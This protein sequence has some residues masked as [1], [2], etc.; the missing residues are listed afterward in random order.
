VMIIL[1]T[2]HTLR[3]FKK[4]DWN[5]FGGLGVVDPTNDLP[6]IN[7]LFH[8][9]ETALIESFAQEMK[10]NIYTFNKSLIPEINNPKNPSTQIDDARPENLKK[11]KNFFEEMLEENKN[12]FAA[13]RMS[14]KKER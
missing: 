13:I 12:S 5:S 7:I 10:G 4:D 3:S 8:A 11:L 6:L 14:L 2:G 9:S 1:G